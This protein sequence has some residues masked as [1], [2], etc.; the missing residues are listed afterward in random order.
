MRIYCTLFLSLILSTTLNAQN[1]KQNLQEKIA[2]FDS[3]VQKGMKAWQIPGMAI[4]IVK[5]NEIVFTKGYGVRETGTDKKVDTKTY[6]TCA[7]TTKAMTAICMAIYKS[8]N[9]IICADIERVNESV[10]DST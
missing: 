7:S 4:S 2:A 1:K 10:Q 8:H 5:D 6:F 9:G 3:Y